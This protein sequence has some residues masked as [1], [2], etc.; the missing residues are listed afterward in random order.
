MISLVGIDTSSTVYRLTFG[1]FTLLQGF[2]VVP[3]VVGLFGIAEVL[4][5]IRSNVTAVVDANV[6]VDSLYPTKEE[7]RLSNG[8]T[9]R[10][11]VLGTALGILPGSRLRLHIH[12]LL[13]QQETSG[14]AQ[15]TGRGL[16]RGLR[17]REAANN[18][19]AMAGF[20]P[21]LALGIPTGPV[22]SIVLA[23]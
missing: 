21:L 12:S 19:A 22:L 13:S 16:D 10:G 6:E 18:A 20:I 4:D 11:S 1:S 17:L 15:Q 9:I 5:G 7:L 8:S 3:I 14:S 23:A 2:D